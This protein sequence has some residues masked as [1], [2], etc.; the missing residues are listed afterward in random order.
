MIFSRLLQWWRP[1]PNQEMLSVCIRGKWH[2]ALP[3]QA[4]GAG[5][6]CV[7]AGVRGGS[8]TFL[9]HVDRCQDTVAYWKAWRA[10]G[11]E[12]FNT[13]WESDGKAVDLSDVC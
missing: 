1:T 11:G 5:L 12:H 8:S 3:Q 9:V 4:C 6:V 10:S 7:V 2:D 13:T